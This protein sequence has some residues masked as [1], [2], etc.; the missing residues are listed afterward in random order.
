MVHSMDYK[1]CSGEWIDIFP[2]LP[3]SSHTYEC[4]EEPI[5]PIPYAEGSWRYGIPAHGDLL[6]GV[7][8]TGISI[9][10]A[11]I[12]I[13]GHF[14]CTKEGLNSS[15]MVISFTEPVPMLCLSTVAVNLNVNATSVKCV[16]SVFGSLYEENRQSVA[17]FLQ[18]LPK[19][20]YR[21]DGNV[22]ILGDGF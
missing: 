5:A 20:I 2:S 18:S 22:A 16:K 9:K 1:H 19:L 21:H 3:L 11:S 13:G 10:K 6:L 14:T 7:K 8:I 17:L 4:E 15:D 12:T